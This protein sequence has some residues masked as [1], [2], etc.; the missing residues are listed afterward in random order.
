MSEAIIEAVAIE[1]SYPQADGTRI[2]VVG[3][4][5][6]HRT[7]KDHRP[8]RSFGL[9]KLTLLRI[10]TGLSATE[11]RHLLAAWQAARWATPNV[12]IV[13]QSFALFR[14]TVLG[15]VEAPLEAK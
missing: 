4:Q 11:L 6:R 2:Q 9:R 1:K 14:L 15:N 10:L 3:D 8:A 13:F 7:G 5:S 12:A